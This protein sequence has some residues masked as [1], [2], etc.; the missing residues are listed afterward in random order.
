MLE[1]GYRIKLVTTKFDSIGVKLEQL[2]SLEKRIEQLE[3]QKDIR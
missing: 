2:Q 1:N 3:G